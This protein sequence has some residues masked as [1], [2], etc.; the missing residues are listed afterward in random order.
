MKAEKRQFC[1]S[2]LIRIFKRTLSY[3]SLIRFFKVSID[4]NDYRKNGCWVKLS[5]NYFLKTYK[6]SALNRKTKCKATKERNRGVGGGERKEGKEK[7][8]PSA[9]DAP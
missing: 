6:T 1:S 3:S 9:T 4:E 2:S 8:P 5:N 7:S